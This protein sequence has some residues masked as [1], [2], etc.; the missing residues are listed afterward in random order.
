MMSERLK[1]KQNGLE[2][3]VGWRIIMT[4]KNYYISEYHIDYRKNKEDRIRGC[5]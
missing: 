4:S 3:K 1:T 2:Q 5:N